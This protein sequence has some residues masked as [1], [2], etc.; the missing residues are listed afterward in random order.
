MTISQ[1]CGYGNYLYPYQAYMP[2]QFNNWNNYGFSAPEIKRD[3]RDYLNR[4]NMN[5]I[6]F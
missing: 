4:H 3:L 2:L 1:V 6:K 5:F